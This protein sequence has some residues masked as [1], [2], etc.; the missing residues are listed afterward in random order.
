MERSNIETRFFEI[1]NIYDYERSCNSLFVFCE[2]IVFW[3][4]YIGG[5]VSGHTRSRYQSEF[6]L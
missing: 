6:Q 2:V 4:S 1:S 5:K 3:S